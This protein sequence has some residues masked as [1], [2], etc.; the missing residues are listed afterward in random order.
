M[1]ATKTVQLPERLRV[2]VTLSNLLQHL[3]SPPNAALNAD[4][5]RSVVSHLVAE[6]QRVDPDEAFEFVL[7]H[8]PATAELYENLHYEHAGLCRS[9][10]SQS[11]S[12]EQL[13][14]AAIDKVRRMAA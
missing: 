14:R 6:L 9:P 2:L 10:L 12:T 7:R 8:F 13:A 1:E 4:Q 5:H 11:L 3:E